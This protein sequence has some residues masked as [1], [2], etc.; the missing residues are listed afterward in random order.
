MQTKS[1]EKEL[2]KLPNVGPKTAHDLLSLGI[3]SVDDL[4]GK[5]PDVLYAE[6]ERKAGTHIDRC[7]LY[8][9]RSLVYMA[10]TGKRNPK[11]VAWWLFK[12]AV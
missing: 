3:H 12:D 6:L 11:D 8:V 5:D 4:I 10:Q 2:Q 7:V 9:M 1:V